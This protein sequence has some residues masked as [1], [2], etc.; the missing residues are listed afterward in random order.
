MHSHLRA[1]QGEQVA[2]DY[3]PLDLYSDDEGRIRKAI[4]NLW[5]GWVKSDATANN[6]KIFAH[7]KFVKPFKV[8]V[9]LKCPSFLADP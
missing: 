4:Y 9:L 6:L 5:D 3:C 1:Q 8:S 2:T 7:G